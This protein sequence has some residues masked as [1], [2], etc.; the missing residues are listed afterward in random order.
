[1][2][3]KSFRCEILDFQARRGRQAKC[4]EAVAELR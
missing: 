3:A 2:V 4:L 1:M